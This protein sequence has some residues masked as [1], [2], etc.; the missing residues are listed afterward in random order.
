MSEIVTDSNAVVISE[1]QKM[2]LFKEFL[3]L[4]KKQATEIGAKDGDGQ[5][6]RVEDPNGKRKKSRN[7]DE[8]SVVESSFVIEGEKGSTSK[9]KVEEWRQKNDDMLSVLVE[10]DPIDDLFNK[11]DSPAEGV[12]VNDKEIEGL[13][14]SRYSK[15]ME[16]TKE[17]MG[18]PLVPMVQKLVNTTWGKLQLAAK[19]K[20][21]LLEKIDIPINCAS[22]KAPRLNTEV[23]IRVYENAAN[24]D[25]AMMDRQRDISK[26]TIPVLK[27]MGEMEKVKLLM[28]KSLREKGKEN[29]SDEDKECYKGVKNSLEELENSVLMLNYNFTETT[30]RRKYD[31][32]Q[33]L[34]AQF[35]PYATSED[36]GEFLFGVETQKLMKSELKKVSVK[37]KKSD[38]TKNSLASG[39]THRSFQGGNRFSPYS[40]NNSFNQNNRGGNQNHYN[41]N[42]NNS[43]NNYNNY[44]NQNRNQSRRGGRKK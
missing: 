5:P 26:A 14:R 12:E 33:A 16:H 6:S 32:C 15:I 3:E 22:M 38:Q 19:T 34:G 44:N 41:G 39:K 10:D 21:S 17:K 29:I 37:A 30:R 24:K 2:P 8:V 42:S 9:K 23:Y 31:V 18:D 25:K 40:R 27:A 28:E 1:E 36:T 7:D 20:T 4:Q 35:R 43:N 13:L 11:D